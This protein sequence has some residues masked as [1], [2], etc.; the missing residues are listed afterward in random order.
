MIKNKSVNLS[1]SC[2]FHKNSRPTKRKLRKI[3]CFMHYYKIFDIKN[4]LRYLRL[5]YLKIEINLGNAVGTCLPIFEV[6]CIGY[7]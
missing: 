7:K 3:L 2:E 4:Q 1:K 5:G 6:N